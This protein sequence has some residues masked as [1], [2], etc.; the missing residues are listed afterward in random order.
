MRAKVMESGTM[1]LEALLQVMNE[2]MVAADLMND[3]TYVIVNAKAIGRL[4]LLERAADVAAKAAPYMHLKPQN[5][6]H[7]SEARGPIQERIV[8]EFVNAAERS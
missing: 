4:E 1:P 6:E 8:V 3:D 7:K 2:L 5:I